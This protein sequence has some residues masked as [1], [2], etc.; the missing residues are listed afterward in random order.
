MF[1]K[2]CIIIF[3]IQKK[4]LFGRGNRGEEKN[5]LIILVNYVYVYN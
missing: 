3:N 4:N 2:V 1:L 5:K